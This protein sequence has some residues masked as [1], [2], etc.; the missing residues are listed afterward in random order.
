M[1]SGQDVPDVL[2]EDFRL[3]AGHLGYRETRLRDYPH[4]A[5]PD[6]FCRAQSALEKS[7]GFLERRLFPLHGIPA[8]G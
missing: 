3:M 4:L 6:D 2:P 7:I 5:Q 8:G 1:M